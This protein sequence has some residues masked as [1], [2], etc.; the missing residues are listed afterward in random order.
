MRIGLISPPWLPVP[1]PAYGGT[2]AVVDRLARGLVAAGHDV[3]LAAPGDSTCPVPRV[4]PIAA[5][6]THRMGENEVELAY[7]VRAY[8]EMS[9]V[10]LVHDHTLAGPLFRCRPPQVPVVVTNHMPFV[11]GYADIYRAAA[12]DAH[13]VAI[14]AHQAAT[15]RGTRIA[16]VIHHG[17]DVEDVPVGSGDGGYVLFLGRMS[18]DKGVREAILAARLAGLPLLL[19]GKSRLPL[20]QDYFAE[21]VEPLLGHGAE[22]IG[23]IDAVRRFG[24]IGAASALLNP[25]QWDE[26]FGLVMIEALACGTPVVATPYGSVPELVDDGVTGYIRRGQEQ[27]AAALLAA[28]RLDRSACRRAA[29]ERFS[30]RRMVTEHVRL[31]HD[32]VRLRRQFS[33]PS[34]LG[35]PARHP[36]AR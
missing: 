24:L 30:T 9:G 4:T 35:S 33:A 19:A 5:A 11:E 13:V 1:P 17:L 7:L 29:E 14:S 31:Y 32:V 23:E 8:S 12:R 22:Y 27:L 10:D 26:P 34:V 15:A 21:Q 6:A 20:E 3:L 18:P 28:G 25:I 16:R 36:A 2:E